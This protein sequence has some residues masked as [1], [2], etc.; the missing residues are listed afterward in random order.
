MKTILALLLLMSGAALAAPQAGPDP[1]ASEE[2]PSSGE[3]TEPAQQQTPPTGDESSV[4]DKLAADPANR[5]HGRMAGD[6]WFDVP[7]TGT[8]LR[9][10]G[11]VQL[12]VIYDP[13]NAGFPFGDFI[14]SL[15]P[16]PTDHTPNTEFDP[17]TSRATFETRTNTEKAGYVTTFM[18]VDFAG[19][20][21]GGSVQPRLRQA[22]VSWVGPQSNIS[23]T[24]GQAW[25]TF[26]DLGVWPEVF[27]LEGPNAM[28]GVRQGLVR[29]S[30]AFG[31][32]KKLV[33]D[34]AVEQAQTFV[35]NGIGLK[36]RPDLMARINWQPG[37]GHV[38][39]AAV[40]R[41]L[42]AESTAG[43]GRDSASGW[44]VSLSGS[45]HVPGTKRKDPPSDNLGVRQDSI[46]FQAQ[47]G[48]GIGRYVFD[49]GAAPT[50]QDAVYD[51]ATGEI[52]PLE[53]VGAFVAYHH[54]WADMWRS[55]VVY[56]VVSVDNLTL[57]PASAL[58]RT[59]YVLV[60]LLYRPFRRMDIGLE[61]YWGER[62]NKDGQ[63]G[64]ASR[65]M[66]AVNFGF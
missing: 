19:S 61:Y 49:L 16:M 62:E 50:P 39:A 15:I 20:E 66:F 9:F 41:R 27:D 31:E 21:S 2:S 59:T 22:T 45:W 26:L 10:G 43:T 23:F 34:G 13:Q 63:T 14:P 29:G 51:D 5:R 64:H 47:G 42:V 40:G 60:N 37:W 18:S 3:S 24:A 25:T 32:S 35:A 8:S 54:W 4:F 46:Q 38:Q 52:I 17:R 56:G 12:N 11:F 7:G 36:D 57:Q 6:G 28:T 48:S 53:E 30:Y 33:V 55:Q 44:G 65:L 58:K 1:A